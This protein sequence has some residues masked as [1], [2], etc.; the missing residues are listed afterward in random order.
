MKE[1]ELSRKSVFTLESRIMTLEG[2]LF[3]AKSFEELY[4]DS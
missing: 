4:N 2:D 1:L 3:K